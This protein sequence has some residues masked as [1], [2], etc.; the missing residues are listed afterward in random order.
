ME[1]NIETY[2]EIRVLELIEAIKKD[3]ICLDPEAIFL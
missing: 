2:T 1:S 3:N